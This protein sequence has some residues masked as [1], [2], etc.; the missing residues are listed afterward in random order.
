MENMST[1]N[2]TDPPGICLPNK[3]PCHEKLCCSFFNLKNLG[4]ARPEKVFTLENYSKKIPTADVQ[5]SYAGENPCAD[6]APA[7]SEFKIVSVGQ[8]RGPVPFTL[9]C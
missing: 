7:V 5:F 6:K 2:M 1:Q 9:P 4:C 3:I 8:T